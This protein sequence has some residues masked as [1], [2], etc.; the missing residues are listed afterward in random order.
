MKTNKV[1]KLITI[2]MIGLAAPAGLSAQTVKDLSLAE[3]I[4]LSIKNSGQLRISQA[5]IE[6]AG[7][8]L[9][10]ARERRLPDLKTNGSYMRLNSP[11]VDL[12]L[13]TG[14][15]QQQTEGAATGT[16]S[17]KVDQAMFGMATLSVPVFSGLRINYGIESARFLKEAAK[18]DAETDKEDIIQNTLNAYSNLYKAGAAVE[19]M[20]ENLRS[21]QE[22]GRELSNLEKNGLLARNDLLKADLQTS[23]I[24]LTLMDAEANLNMAMINMNLMIGLDESTVLKTDASGFNTTA[25]LK[26]VNDWIAIAFQ[27]RKDIAAIDM[28]EKAAIT[29]VK[30][31]KGEYYPSLAITGGYVAAHVPNFLTLTNALNAGVGLQ[32]NFGALWKT[33]AKVQQAKARVIQLQANEGILRDAIKLQVNQAYQA[34]TLAI[35]KISV[36]QKA[37]EQAEENYKITKNKYDNN[38]ATTTELLDA[39]LAQLQARLNF[40]NAKADASVAYNKLLQMT[41]SLNEQ[42]K[43]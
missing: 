27:N 1:H 41:G 21:A 4:E 33:G 19:L 30:A 9:R 28:R 35:K 39:D 12:K 37:I 3:A 8:E 32:Y 16:S 7:A 11:N 6:E 20:K 13:N 14:Q 2:L 43:N 36:Y 5:K 29:A 42:N 23:N 38:L 22:R 34:H 26:T 18:L 24:E 40:A 10:E 17:V 15:Q 31:T 25:D